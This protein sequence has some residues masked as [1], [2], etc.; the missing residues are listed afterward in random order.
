V[1]G[2][3]TLTVTSGYGTVT[4]PITIQSLAPAIFS[5]SPNQPAIANQDNTLNGPSNPA[6]R[7]TAIVIYATGLGAVSG[8][9]SL[10]RAVTLVSV[11]VG[12]VEIP[13]FFAGLSPGTNG[14]YQANVVLPPALPPGLSLSL[15]IKQGTSVSNQV[16]V[17]VQ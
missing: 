5:V 1:P 7:G 8:S 4:Q 15:Y 11:V 3:A 16:S 12:G 13:V 9:G 10:M 14:L 17:A 2:P 6:V